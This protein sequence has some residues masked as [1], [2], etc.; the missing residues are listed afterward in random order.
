MDEKRVTETC[1][2]VYMCVRVLCTC[3]GVHPRSLPPP[4]PLSTGVPGC[5]GR[6]VRRGAVARRRRVTMG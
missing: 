1:V 4:P 6:P 2:M 5:P 3:T